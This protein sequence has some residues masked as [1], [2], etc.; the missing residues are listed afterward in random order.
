MRIKDTTTCKDHLS[1]DI[2]SLE[3]YPAERCVIPCVI[4]LIDFFFLLLGKKKN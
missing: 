2:L 4:L 1:L 3:H